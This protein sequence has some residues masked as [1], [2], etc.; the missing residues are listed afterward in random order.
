VNKTRDK[1]MMANTKKS[2]G[3]FKEINIFLVLVVL[4][5]SFGVLNKRFISIENISNLLRSTSIIGVVAIGMTFVIISGGI[6]LSVG[7]VLALSSV[8]AARLMT[9]GV[10]IYL[11]IIISLISGMI[12]G[13]IMGVIIYEAKVPP[14]IVTLAGLVVFRGIAMLVTSAKKIIGLPESFTHFAVIKVLGLPA[15]AILWLLLIS[16][17][18]VVAR[19]TVFGRNIYAIG[20]NQEAARLS[21]INIRASIYQVYALCGLTS[22]IA[23]VLMGARLAGG[24]PSAGSGY[25]L[26]AIAAS[27]LGGTS[28][29]GGIGGVFGTFF[30]TMI[31]ATIS[32]G[33]N[34][35]GVNPFVLEIIVGVLIVL[36]VVFDH[37]QK[38]RGTQFKI[39]TKE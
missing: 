23:G 14:F 35:M 4:V 6:D 10:P 9:S 20:S 13:L 16:I 27:V 30:G 24:S 25:E 29:A 36:A 17:G 39:K 38:R 22:A 3:R 32:N 2:I 18:V 26:D 5:I 7:S 34:I 33:G 37:L 8:I 19:F 1:K 12:A 28:L 15:M 31:I 21:G 11:S